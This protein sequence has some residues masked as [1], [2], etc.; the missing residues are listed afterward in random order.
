MTKQKAPCYQCAK[1]HIG[2]HATCEEYANYCALLKAE[3]DSRAAEINHA[4]Y[5]NHLRNGVYKKYPF[6][7]K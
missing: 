3:K 5:V 6:P 4:A 7:K 1:R 2:C